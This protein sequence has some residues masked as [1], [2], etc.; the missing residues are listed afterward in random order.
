MRQ[1]PIDA[2]YLRRIPI[3][4]AMAMAGAPLVLA[5][6]KVTGDVPKTNKQ[7]LT[8]TVERDSELDTPVRDLHFAKGAL[9]ENFENLEVEVKSEDGEVLDGWVVDVRNGKVNVYSPDGEI[10]AGKTT[11]KLTID[12]STEGDDYE[13]GTKTSQKTEL[14]TTEDGDH[15]TA[16]DHTNETLTT[17]GKEGHLAATISAD[18]PT[19]TGDTLLSPATDPAFIEPFASVSCAYTGSEPF[20]TAPTSWWR[21]LPLA[22]LG[23]AGEFVTTEVI[24]PVEAAAHPDGTQAITVRLYLDLDGGAPGIDDLD[25]LA[26]AGLSA[27]DM[28]LSTISLPISARLPADATL[29]ME[30]QSDDGSSPADPG[31]A[32]GGRFFIGGN[33]LDQPTPSYFSSGPCGIEEPVDIRDLGFGLSL[34]VQVL[35]YEQPGCYPDLDGD[36]SLT[37]FDFLAFQNL[38]D[39]GDLRADCDGSGEL[40]LFDFLCFQ[41]TFDAGCP[42][43]A[44]AI[45][46]VEPD[47]ARPGEELTI[48]GSGFGDAADE[49]RVM[50]GAD[51]AGRGGVE[52]EVLDVSPTELRVRL[53]ETEGVGSGDSVVISIGEVID[54]APFVSD[55]FDD[56]SLAAFQVNTDAMRLDALSIFSDVDL[57]TETVKT[58]VPHCWKV[59]GNAQRGDTQ[60]VVVVMTNPDGSKTTHTRKATYKGDTSES[61][62]SSDLADWLNG[63]PGVTASYDSVKNKITVTATNVTTITVTTTGGNHT[64]E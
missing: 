16:N 7:C 28:E 63:L 6:T 50:L 51:D 43:S 8:F 26:A 13:W 47:E 32:L 12:N 36:G 10:P 54:P 61:D 2:S 18:P 46:A 24:I 9:P 45:D 23:V 48:F 44:I 1:R 41:N 31:T 30:V 57:S 56:M 35:G 39:T 62:T 38:F 55:V 20:T 37:L 22:D 53:P 11:I 3:I 42:G 27:D 29:V 49:I 19:R 15:L 64:I 25:L 59:S 40:N 21:S 5:D 60:K 52:A 17:H 33:T 14:Y 34:G 4:A 58:G